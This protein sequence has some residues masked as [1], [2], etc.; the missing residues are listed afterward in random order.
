MLILTVLFAGLYSLVEI[1]YGSH[2]TVFSP[3][4]Y[5]IVTLTTLG[6]GD[7]VP[8]SVPGQVLAVT[9]AILGYVGLGGLLS[10]LSNK[11]ARRAD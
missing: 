3:L 7:V 4:Y 5:S 9:Q 2:R 8:A 6:Y 10:I 1:D 11:M